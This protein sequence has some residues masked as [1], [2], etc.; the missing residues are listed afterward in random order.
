[1]EDKRL[2][3]RTHIYQNHTLDST[4]WDAF[5]PRDDDIVIATPIKSGTTW[6]QLI[7]WQLIF[8]DSEPLPFAGLSPWLDCAPPHLEDV[9]ETLEAQSHRRFIKTHLPLDGLPYYPQVKYI[10]VGRDP[11]DVFMSLWNH[12]R[13]MAQ[14]GFEFFNDRSDRVGPPLPA[15]PQDIR[16]FWANWINR[17]WFDWETEGYPFWSYLRHVQTWWDF[18]HLPNILFIHFNDLLSNLLGEI[19]RV[20]DYLDI[21]M[22]QDSVQT[23]ADAVSL[24]SVKNDAE[25]LMPQ[26]DSIWVGGAQTFF[27]KGTN[28]RWRGVLTEA[29]L[30]MYDEAATR[31]LTADCRAWLEMGSSHRVEIDES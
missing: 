29:D 16:E 17:G 27:N 18:R 6:M 19:K 28:G 22:P 21:A 20:A 26:A 14:G 31:E 2:P 13:N 9:I 7:V 5:T 12:H 24:S 23:I 15:C 8:Q 10:F 11:R 30:Q 25:T 1:M 4:R 3:Q